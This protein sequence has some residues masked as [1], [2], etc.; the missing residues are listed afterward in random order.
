[1]HDAGDRGAA[2]VA[3]VGCGT[4]NRTG[5]RDATEDAGKNIPESLTDQLGVGFVGITDHSVRDDSGQQGFDACQQRD[6]KGR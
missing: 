6:G 3:D 1:M 5:C 4:G 2:A